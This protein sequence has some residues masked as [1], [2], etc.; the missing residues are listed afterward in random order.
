MGNL[1]EFQEITISYKLGNTIKSKSQV[2][3]S[4]SVRITCAKD[5][6]EILRHN[7]LGIEHR[8]SFYILLLNR[9][10]KV[11]GISLVSMGGLSGT[12]ADP[13]IIYQTALKAN[14]SGI[15]LAHNHP[16]GNL[17]PSSADIQLTSKLKQA[18]QWLDLPIL[19]HIIMSE[20]S[21]LSFAEDG[22]L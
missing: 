20:D 4:D 18:G 3:S 11:L 6:A 9:A 2:K 13:K 21:F 10:N 19:D 1:N 12:A 14:A 17:Q 22:L 8:E 16:S 7:W 5:A 15:I